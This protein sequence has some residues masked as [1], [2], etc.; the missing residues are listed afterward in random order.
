MNEE[1]D[2]LKYLSGEADEAL[3]KE[4][5][6]WKLEGEQNADNLKAYERIWKDAESLKGYR[7]F[8]TSKAWDAVAGQ[9][10]FDISS[11]AKV[12]SI[13]RKRYDI[14]SYWA[15]A[16]SLLLLVMA[17]LYFLKAEP[18]LYAEVETGEEWQEITLQDGSVITLQSNSK[19]RYPT[20][21]EVLDERRVFLEGDAV[22][23]IAED[24]DKDFVTENYGAGVL[25]IGTEYSIV[26]DSARSELENIGGVM[27]MFELVDTSNEVTLEKPGDKAVFDGGPIKFIPAYT[28]PDTPGVYLPME[29]I[30][31]RLSELF[32]RDFIP[33]P[34][35]PIENIATAKIDLDQPLID[36]FRQ[37]DS[38]AHVEYTVNP[39][40]TITLRS[41][42][43]K[44]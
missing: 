13:T 7:S 23:A 21:F 28:P 3:L 18:E 6:A 24:P 25:A 34:Y 10:D 8:D 20:T 14:W 40:G 30:V 17:G 43:R 22:V 9:L 38:T 39:D 36:I 42:R 32:E 27:Q 35:A 4:I 15:V 2:I 37:L 16:A 5:E 44:E 33:A 26:S 41:L 19:L 31:E 1:K 12:I 29:N 11:E